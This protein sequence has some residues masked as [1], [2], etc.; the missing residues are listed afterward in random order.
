MVLVLISWKSAYLFLKDEG[1]H[2][3][4]QV[5]RGN[6]TGGDSVSEG[7]EFDSLEEL[8]VLLADVHVEV[9]VSLG[10]D[11]DLVGF[12]HPIVAGGVLLLAFHDLPN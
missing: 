7:V 4:D 10:G 2:V 5:L 12:G 9:G 3:P 6:D 1:A 11:V 8:E